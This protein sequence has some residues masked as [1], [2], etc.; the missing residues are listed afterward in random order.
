[1]E[2]M[3]VT[4]FDTGDPSSIST[5]LKCSLF[6]TLIRLFSHCFKVRK[7]TLN[8]FD[9]LMSILTDKRMSNKILDN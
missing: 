3:L 9:D 5:C 6:A 1:M 7:E 2:Y 8:S 4:N